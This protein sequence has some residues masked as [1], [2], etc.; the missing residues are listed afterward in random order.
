V[1]AGELGGSVA[2][3]RGVRRHP[4]AARGVVRARGDFAIAIGFCLRFRRELRLSPWATE[5]A[6]AAWRATSTAGPMPM[7]GLAGTPASTAEAGT[8]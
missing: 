3:V 1:A 2:A 4:V 6:G 7:P 8:R 5:S